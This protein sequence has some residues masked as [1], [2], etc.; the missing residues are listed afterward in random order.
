[1]KPFTKRFLLQ[2]I[3]GIF[4]TSELKKLSVLDEINDTINDEP[5][6]II[7]TNEGILIFMFNC[8]YYYT[9]KQLKKEEDELIQ[10]NQDL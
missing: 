6:K 7:R 5:L 8:D 3:S 2:L 1:M 10:M 4:L 9:F